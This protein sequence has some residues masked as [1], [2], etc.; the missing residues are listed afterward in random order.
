PSEA[1]A[2]A[3]GDMAARDAA[4][5]LPPQTNPAP[6]PPSEKHYELVVDAASWQRWWNEV[7]QAELVSLSLETTV[8][9]PLQAEIVGL[10]FATAPGRRRDRQ[11]R[12]AHR[13]RPGRRRPRCRIRGR[14][15]RRDAA[16]ACPPVSA[17]R[18]RRQ[19]AARVRDDRAAGARRAV[20]HGAHGRADRRRA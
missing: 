6:L 9:E 7:Q 20:P 1:P 11:G 16:P 5:A 15:R 17:D 2:E 4:E 12:Q 10:S 14:G 3:A 18:A 8:Q 19:A 13:L